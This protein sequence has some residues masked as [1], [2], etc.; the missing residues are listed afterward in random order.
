MHRELADAFVLSS[1]E[2]EDVFNK[3]KESPHD[4]ELHKPEDLP[5]CLPES[6]RSPS[7]VNDK[8]SGFLFLFKQNNFSPFPPATFHN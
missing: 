5:L 3:E 1:G 6:S 7:P 8:V 4:T 2:M